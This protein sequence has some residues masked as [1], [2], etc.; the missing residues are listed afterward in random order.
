MCPH[1]R[2]RVCVCVCVSLSVSMC[3]PVCLCVCAAACVR[4]RVY[5]H[6]RVQ[7]YAHPALLTRPLSCPPCSASLAL[8]ASTQACTGPTPPPLSLSPSFHVRQSCRS[9]RG[10]VVGR[11]YVPL[12]DLL[13]HVLGSAPLNGGGGGGAGGGGAGGAGGG[14]A[15]RRDMGVAGKPVELTLPFEDP[16]LG[17]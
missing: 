17:A 16:E 4:P 7:L 12:Y 9:R 11:L 6:G 10:R 8:A 5:V 3:V 15:A 14:P 13:D 2:L 1:V